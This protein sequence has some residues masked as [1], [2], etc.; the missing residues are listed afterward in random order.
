MRR[1]RSKLGPA[2][3]AFVLLVGAG[4]AR[5]Q[6]ATDAALRDRVLQLVERL[7]APK[8]E[9]QKAAEDA[10]VKLGPRILPLLPEPTKSTSAARK[11]RLERIRAALREVEEESNL[12]AAKVT[13]Q[14]QGIRLTEA[15]QKLQAQSGN[16]IT[17]LREQMGAAVTN[18]GLD[19]DIVAKPFFEALDVIARKAEVTPYFTTGDSTVGLMAGAPPAAAQVQYS[20]PFRIALKQITAVRDFQSG[21][22]SANVQFEVAWEPR[23]RPMLLALDTDELAITDD[24]GQEIEPQVMNESTDVVLRPENPA[25]EINVNLAAP[26]RAAKALARLKVK[27]TVTVP[28]GI[29]TFRFPNLAARDVAQKQGDI[30]IMLESTDVDE[31]VWK[32]N[33]V[34]EY[35]G[36]GPAFESYRQGL[37]NNRLWLQKPDGAR[38]EHNGGFSNTA[39][40]QGKLGFEYLFVDVPGKPANYQLVYET[41][42]KVLTIPLEFEFKDVPLP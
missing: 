7:D 1:G 2:L 33:V 14:G 21:M 24:R 34:L 15:I 31:Q 37:F 8:T 10:L 22:S 5:G 40:D 11:E 39:S 13:I 36:E 27:A 16:A 35:P 25:A 20:G 19:L 26:D 28:A 17:D 29:R 30:R 41:P 23:L 6:Q 18:P 12:G 32:V 4:Q 38:F 3:L 9:A 42:S